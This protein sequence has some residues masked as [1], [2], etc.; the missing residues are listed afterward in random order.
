MHHFFRIH[1]IAYR[2]TRR[3]E[4]WESHSAVSKEF[5]VGSASRLLANCGS[6]F[7]EI[8]NGLRSHYVGL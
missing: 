1:I 5:N 7:F 8:G 6:L 2:L 3:S 4:F